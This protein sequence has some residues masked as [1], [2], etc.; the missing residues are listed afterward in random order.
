MEAGHAGFR[1][2]TREAQSKVSVL[3]AVLIRPKMACART[4]VNI[5]VVVPSLLCVVP[6][7]MSR[8]SLFRSITDVVGYEQAQVWVL[9]VL[10]SPRCRFLT[11]LR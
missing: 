4:V 6:A 1:V 2:H 8:R 10:S 9:G 3:G 11:D 7:I 5:R